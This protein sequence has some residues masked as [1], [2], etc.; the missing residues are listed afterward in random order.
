MTADDPDMQGWRGVHMAEG[1]L[2]ELLGVSVDQAARGL[3]AYV[4]AVGAV[5]SDVARDVVEL[6][7]VIDAEFC[8]Q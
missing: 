8:R 1:V 6:R 2:A 4:A 5:L 7:L 3:R